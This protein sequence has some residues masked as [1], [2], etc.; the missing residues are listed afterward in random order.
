MRVKQPPVKVTLQRIR[1]LHQLIEKQP[2]HGLDLEL[3]EADTEKYRLVHRQRAGL[4]A[5]DE[6]H[7]EDLTEFKER[8]DFSQLTQG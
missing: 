8:R 6:E 1:R 7:V 3:D 4:S 2:Q 5:S